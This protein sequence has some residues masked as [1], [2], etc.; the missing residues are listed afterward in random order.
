MGTFGTWDHGDPISREVLGEV[1]TC[2]TSSDTV[3]GMK[4]T[5]DNLGCVVAVLDISD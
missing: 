2:G 3:L 5:M 1:G 4:C